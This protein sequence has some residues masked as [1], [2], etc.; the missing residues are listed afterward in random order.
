MPIKVIWDYTYYWAL[1][2]PLFFGRRLTDVPLIGKLRPQ[3]LRGRQLNLAVQALLREW[4]QCNTM[5]LQPDDRFLN[6]YEI[7]WFHEMNRALLDE[8]D[9]AAFMKRIGDNVARMEWLAREILGRARS[10]HPE[11]GGHGLDELL[12]DSDSA[13]ISLAAFWYA[14]AA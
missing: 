5:P 13:E 12:A 3:F 2:A 7:D 8:L 9:D 10:E 14:D 4:G 11:I 6:Q 1:L